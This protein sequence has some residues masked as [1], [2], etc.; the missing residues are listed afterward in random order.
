[1]TISTIV[2]NN[3]TIGANIGMHTRFLFESHLYPKQE[4]KSKILDAYFPKDIT[5]ANKGRGDVCSVG[6]EPNTAHK[7]RLQLLSAYYKS[8]GVAFLRDSERRI[9]CVLVYY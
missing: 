5:N 4:Y 6:F 7:S 3:I 1:M 2:P 9:E 8:Q